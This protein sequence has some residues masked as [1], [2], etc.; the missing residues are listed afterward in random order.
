MTKMALLLLSKQAKKL[1][2]MATNLVSSIASLKSIALGRFD[3]S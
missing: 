1:K 3:V 2:I